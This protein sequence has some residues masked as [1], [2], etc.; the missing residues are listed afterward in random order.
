MPQAYAA[1]VFLAL[2]ALVGA[3]EIQRLHQHSSAS[4]ASH[5]TALAQA[6]KSKRARMAT[7]DVI[8]KLRGVKV[9]AAKDDESDDDDDD[10]DDED[11]GV[12]GELADTLEKNVSDNKIIISDKTL[13]A[14][15]ALMK[16]VQ[17]ANDADKKKK[18]EDKETAEKDKRQKEEGKAAAEK[19]QK[20]AKEK[21]MVEAAAA[22]EQRE[23]E[24]A[25]RAARKKQE[26]IDREFKFFKDDEAFDAKIAEETKLM[27]NETQSPA[28]A[29]FLGT[30]RSEMRNYAMPAYPAYLQSKLD[31]AN[32]KLK[33]WRLKRTRRF[34]SS[35][36]RRKLKS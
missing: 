1:F 7:G 28:L 30:F 29:S 25:L 11:D 31:A 21:R 17:E 32:S 13:A 34:Q 6:L 2:L 20:A 24:E 10:D 5:A 15:T 8:H 27:T 33:L 19:E 26:T 9:D 4:V 16:G 23:A 3:V 12:G 22:K 36:Q 35:H 18:G 14:S